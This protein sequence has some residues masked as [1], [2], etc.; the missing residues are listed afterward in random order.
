M[1]AE[2]QTIYGSDS[3]PVDLSFSASYNLDANWVVSP[4]LSYSLNDDAGP[5]ALSVNLKRRFL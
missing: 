4:R 5:A 3:E 2:G 1:K